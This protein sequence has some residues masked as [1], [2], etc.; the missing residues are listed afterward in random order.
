MDFHEFIFHLRYPKLH[1][2][3][4]FLVLA[5]LVFSNGKVLG[6]IA[7]FGFENY[8]V[9]FF[10][11]MVFA[12]GVT[13]PFAA[14]FFGFAT[15]DNIFIAAIMSGL[16]AMIIDFIVFD[17]VRKTLLEE[18][19]KAK[20]GQI[21]KKVERALSHSLGA[22]FLPY[23]SFVLA[24]LVIAVPLPGHLDAVLVSGMAR[25]KR[26]RVALTSFLVY[27]IAALFFLSLKWLLGIAFSL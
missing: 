22:I 1:F 16:G 19:S 7:G 18:L 3:A 23:I 25:L 4:V 5:S 14:G 21:N 15:P 27:F 24:G 9:S 17:F 11:G 13:A 12:L 10:M 26:S 8:I 6:I 2:L 20:K